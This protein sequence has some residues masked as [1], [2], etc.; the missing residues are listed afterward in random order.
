LF[1]LVT[2]SEQCRARDNSSFAI[3]QLTKL[4]EEG[5]SYVTSV[6]LILGLISN[7]SMEQARE[8]LDVSQGETGG[9]VGRLLSPVS[10]YE[11]KKIMIG[12]EFSKL[13]LK[14]YAAELLEAE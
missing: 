1:S 10:N 8:W 9:E 6:C 4:Y 12:S 14:E 3:E 11:K 2:L 7:P 5:P 13:N